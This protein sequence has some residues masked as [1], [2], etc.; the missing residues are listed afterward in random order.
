MRH[1]EAKPRLLSSPTVCFRLS[2]A[3][4]QEEI[5]LPEQGSSFLQASLA[6][7]EFL[8]FTLILNHLATPVKKIHHFS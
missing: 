2:L 5:N 7:A 1:R 6:G 4:F 3:R 8:F